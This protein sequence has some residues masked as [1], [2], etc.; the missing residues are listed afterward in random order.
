M[1]DLCLWDHQ[2]FIA[3][4][5]RSFSKNSE[6]KAMILKFLST[7]T[8]KFWVF[9]ISV[10]FVQFNLSVRICWCLERCG[11]TDH[12]SRFYC[13]EVAFFDFGCSVCFRALK[14]KKKVAFQPDGM[15]TVNRSS[16]FPS[17][18]SNFLPQ[19]GNV[20]GNVKKKSVVKKE[21]RSRNFSSL[22]RL[23]LNI[24][25]VKTCLV[26]WQW[27]CTLMSKEI[28][29]RM[30]T[31]FFISLSLFHKSSFLSVSGCMFRY[32]AAEVVVFLY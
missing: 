5:K 24:G 13:P 12:G 25:M 1:Q 20:P 30:C 27:N 16:E 11:C 18:P 22:G 26:N 32:A 10:C 31:S 6:N 4:F 3:F 8:L 15:I 29:W 14:F 23:F 17:I 19:W 2:A 28:A 21:W 9:E 7:K